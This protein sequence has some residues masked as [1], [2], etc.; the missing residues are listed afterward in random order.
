MTRP[1]RLATSRVT[2]IMAWR[3][4]VKLPAFKVTYRTREGVVRCN[5]PRGLDIIHDPTNAV[6]ASRAASLAFRRIESMVTKVLL[7]L[8]VET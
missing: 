4:H 2:V 6:A 3:M 8:M 5:F 7:L 1:V